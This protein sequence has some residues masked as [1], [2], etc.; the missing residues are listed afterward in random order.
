MAKKQKSIFPF[1]FKLPDTLPSSFEFKKT[2]SLKYRVTGSAYVKYKN[3]E[4]C[5]SQSKEA[6][7]VENLEKSIHDESKALKASTQAKL[8]GRS[9]LVKVNHARIPC[10]N[11]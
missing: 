11:N 5:Q 3:K 7:I 8:L 1:S 2:A 6:C 4:F 10:Q 9:G